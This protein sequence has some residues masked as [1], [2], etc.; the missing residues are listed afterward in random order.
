MI[1]FEIS[2]WIDFLNFL[3][4]QEIVENFYPELLSYIE[5]NLNESKTITEAITEFPMPLFL[6]DFSNKIITYDHYFLNFFQ[7]DNS[8]SEINLNL[9]EYGLDDEIEKFKLSQQ[10]FA[11]IKK[12]FKQLPFPKNIEQKIILYK[13][14]EKINYSKLSIMSRLLVLKTSKVQVWV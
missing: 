10:N 5:K 9:K 2:S 6:A 11:L 14:N 8:S 3:K 1:E 12:Q 7:P 4:N 13:R